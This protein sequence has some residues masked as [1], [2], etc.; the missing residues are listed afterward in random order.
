VPNHGIR[1]ELKEPQGLN[2]KPA[3][4]ALIAGGLAEIDRQEANLR[5]RWRSAKCLADLDE[6]QK[7]LALCMQARQK[8]ELPQKTNN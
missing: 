2:S 7:Q 8:L 6:V 3:L 4:A 5:L 1:S